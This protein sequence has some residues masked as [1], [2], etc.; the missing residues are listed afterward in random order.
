LFNYFCSVEHIF[1]LLRLRVNKLVFYL[2]LLLFSVFLNST[3]SYTQSFEKSLKS[4]LSKEDQRKFLKYDKLMAKGYA[5]IGDDP[6]MPDTMAKQ[7]QFSYL[8]QNHQIAAYY[9]SHLDASLNFKFAIELKYE[10]LNKNLTS[11]WKKYSGDPKSVEWLSSAQS[12]SFNSLLKADEIRQKAD[13]QTRIAEKIPLLKNAEKLEIH[14]EFQME[15]VLFVLLNMP[16]DP[17]PEWLGSPDT[18]NPLISK[19][20][21]KTAPKEKPLTEVQLKDGQVRDTSLY[22]LLHITEQQVDLFN[23]FLL[24]K[25]PNQVENYVIDF[26]KMSPAKIDSLQEEWNSFELGEYITSDTS[27]ANA[28]SK[29]NS[30]VQNLAQILKDAKNKRLQ[31]QKFRETSQNK[32]INNGQS[33][34]N[35]KPSANK[36]NPSDQPD[37]YYRVQIAACRKELSQKEMKRRWEH[38]DQVLVSFEDNWFKYTIGSFSEYKSAQELRNNSRVKGAFV[39]A[40]LNGKRIKITPYLIIKNRP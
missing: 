28:M 31:I 13:I 14:A 39:V 30:P 35:L 7:D 10:V 38:P 1:D 34:D 20:Q 21:S 16:V 9:L 5:I 24:Q 17:I 36:N 23:D 6:F 2:L 27:V 29:K 15:K 33:L 19:Q 3:I 18:I 25:F 11:C 4:K 40:Y 22:S 8:P 37:F 26:E 12:T 32:A